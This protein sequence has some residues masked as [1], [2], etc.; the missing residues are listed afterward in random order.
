M[1]N[2]FIS[3]ILIILLLTIPGCLKKKN[4]K[5]ESQRLIGVKVYQ[6]DRELN[7]LFEE[8]VSLGINTV[9][10]SPSVFSDEFKSLAQEHDIQTFVILPVFYDPATLDAD[11]DLYAITDK[12][13]KA[14]ED[15]VEFVCPSR[16]DYR[17]LKTEYI[18]KLIRELDP[19]GISL[20][21]IRFFCF[22]EK[23]YPDRN[24]DSIPNTCFCPYCLERFQSEKQVSIPDSVRDSGSVSGWIQ[25]NHIEDWTA[26]KCSIITSMVED[27]VTEAKK[28]KPT[29]KVNLHVVPWRKDDFNNAIKRIV[30]QDF[31]LL[32]KYADIISPMTYAHMVKQEPAWIHSVVSDIH[33][34]AECLIIP[35]I[36]VNEAYLLESLSLEDF[37]QS[38][39]EALK[40]PSS[41]VFFWSWEQLESRPEKK[42]VLKRVL[43]SFRE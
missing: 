39:T 11:P 38:V 14:I 9:F 13:E 21:F 5:D 8:W 15:W 17:L 27:I 25:T 10:A 40:P 19:D 43:I 35:S 2:F 32:S 29:I 22:W 1:K 18:L 28:L 16:E 41:G 20:D 26:W 42:E 12:G 37:E 24:P 4:Y 23:V 7:N 3:G 36:Q 33:E 31:P 6:I 34:Q 30:A